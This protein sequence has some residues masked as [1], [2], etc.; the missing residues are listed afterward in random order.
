MNRSVIE[1][2]LAEKEAGGKARETL[3]R[4]RTDLEQF[5]NG[6]GEKIRG[7]GQAGGHRGPELA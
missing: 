6:S 7:V 1:S 2:F 5:S 3:K 4:Y